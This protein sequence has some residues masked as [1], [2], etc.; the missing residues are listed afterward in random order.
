MKKL[1][2]LGDVEET[3]VYKRLSVTH[4]ISKSERKA[5][6]EKLA[7]AK[8]L[9]DEEKSRKYKYIVRGP[10]WERSKVKVLVKK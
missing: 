2:K 9:N 7:E 4:D 3:N 10:L 1:S 8:E 5:N 6:R